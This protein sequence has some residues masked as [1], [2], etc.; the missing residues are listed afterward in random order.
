M[1]EIILFGQQFTWA[2]NLEMTT[3]EI[4][5]RVLPSVEWEQKYP[6][7][8]VCALQRGL[9]DHTPLLMDPGVTMHV[10]NKAIFLFELLD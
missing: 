1:I 3:Y 7:I 10:G 2:N 8:I 9:C 5:N 4:L 6:H